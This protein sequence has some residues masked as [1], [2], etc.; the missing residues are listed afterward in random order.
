MYTVVVKR[1]GNLLD[2]EIDAR[3]VVCVYCIANL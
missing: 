3:L 1:F 2:M